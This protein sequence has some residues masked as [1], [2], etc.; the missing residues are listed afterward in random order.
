MAKQLTFHCTVIT[1]ERPVLECEAVFVAFPA[2]DGELGVLHNR[3]PLVCKLGVGPLRVEGPE[4][5]HKLF[6]DGGFAQ[7]AENRLSILT[8]LA[9]DAST[10]NVAAA[11]KAMVEARA[12]P[13]SDDASFDVRQRAIQRAKVQLKL[14]RG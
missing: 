13:I 12:L 8:E 6:I 1:P 14:A 9:G 2:H 7:V 5:N 10:L 11:E 3:A 4:G